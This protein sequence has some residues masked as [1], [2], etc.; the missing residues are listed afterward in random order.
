[1]IIYSSKVICS[2]VPTVPPEDTY[3]DLL[4]PTIAGAIYGAPTVIAVIVSKLNRPD[5]TELVCRE[6]TPRIWMD[7]FV[8]APL[9]NSAALPLV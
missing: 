2:S 9:C 7:K 6:A 8:H 4:R 3:H 1:M 5:R